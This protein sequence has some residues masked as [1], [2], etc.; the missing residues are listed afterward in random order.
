MKPRSIL[1]LQ[2]P[3][4]IFLINA[5][6]GAGGGALLLELLADGAMKL[7]LEDGLGLDGLEFGLEV[8]KLVGRR[9]AATACIVEVVGHVFDFI[10]VSTPEV[11]SVFDH[12]CILWH[13]VWMHEITDRC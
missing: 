3:V 12:V 9:V 5:L 6:V 11:M 8:L 4:V 2:L 10:A 13:L 7:F 1:V